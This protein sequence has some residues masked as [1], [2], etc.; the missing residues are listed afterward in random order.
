MLYIDSVFCKNSIILQEILKLTPGI[1]RKK[2]LT[3]NITVYEQCLYTKQIKDCFLESHKKFIDIQICIQGYEQIK[4]TNST[5]IKI[6]QNYNP[7]NDCIIYHIKNKLKKTIMK[8]KHIA[9][10]FP[11]DAHMP[12]IKQ[13]YISKIYK[14]VLK[15]PIEFL[16]DFNTKRSQNEMLFMW[17]RKTRKKSR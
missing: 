1:N 4:F 5:L 10:F 15:I 3:N 17:L 7:K 6:K 9:I 11:D 2:I 13:K 8:K 12:L 16:N 14:I